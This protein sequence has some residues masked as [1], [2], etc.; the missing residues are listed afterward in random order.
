MFKTAKRSIGRKIANKVG[1]RTSN[2]A[3]TVTRKGL[4]K[5][6]P[7][8]EIKQR[9]N[10]FGFGD[11]LRRLMV[12]SN[13]VHEETGV[14]GTPKEKVPANSMKI[15]TGLLLKTKGATPSDVEKILKKHGHTLLKIKNA[16]AH[17]GWEKIKGEWINTKDIVR[18]VKKGNSDEERGFRLHK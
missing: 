7:D 1:E 10:K 2:L 3:R 16:M 11:P 5:K 9:E 12:R 17:H 13:I 18:V 15:I 14:L 6:I 4:I 8:R